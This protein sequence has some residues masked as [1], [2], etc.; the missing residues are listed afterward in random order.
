VSEIR[1]IPCLLL[2]GYGLVKTVRFKDPRYIGDPIN[3]VRIFNDKE[4][5][6]LVFLDIGA[7][8]NGSEPNYSL[9]ADIAAESFMPLS[10][11]GGVTSLDQAKRLV[12]IGVEKVIV[13]SAFV[14]RPGFIEEMAASLGRQS[15][16]VAIDVVRTVFGRYEVVTH[17]ATRKAK[18]D[19]VAWAR[20]SESAGAGEILL[21]SVDRDGRMEGYDLDLIKRVSSAVN[22]P[23]V[24]CGGAGKTQDF[25]PAVEQAGA[26]AV[27]AGSMFV[28]HGKHRAVLITYPARNE[29]MAIFGRG[30]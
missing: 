8:R 12:S 27:A 26:S 22:I 11:G 30:A 28:Y 14:E 23:V 25:V 13:N 5:D 9:I 18:L 7:S 3:A 6:E 29:L 19:V 20:Q 1:V 10:Y 2:Q 21:N 16:V 4:V 17:S 15:T 24:A